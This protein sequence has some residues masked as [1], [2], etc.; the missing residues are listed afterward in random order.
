[1]VL[2]E[3]EDRRM[4]ELERIHN[5][6]KVD[7]SLQM[8]RLKDHFEKEI[9][10]RDALTTNLGGQVSDLNSKLFHTLSVLKIPRLHD[11][12]KRRLNFSKYEITKFIPVGGKGEEDTTIEAGD[13]N[14][15]RPMTTIKIRSVSPPSR[16]KH[17]R[18]TFNLS[19]NSMNSSNNGG[20]LSLLLNRGQQK[21]IQTK[22]KSC[23][24]L[25]GDLRYKKST[26]EIIF[27]R[28]R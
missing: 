13:D 5:L 4:S 14:Y 9:K 7:I 17:H 24:K 1:M 6:E 10:V 25:K 27:S 28:S 2:R 16:T 26:T 3:D 23:E 22:Q 11:I 18:S 20:G 21:G 15:R 12:V 8:N 19:R